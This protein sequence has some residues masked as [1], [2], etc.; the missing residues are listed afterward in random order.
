MRHELYKRG[1]TEYKAEP[2]KDQ[3]LAKQNEFREGVSD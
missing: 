3:G 2:R 1:Y